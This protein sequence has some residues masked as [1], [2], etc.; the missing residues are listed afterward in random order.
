LKGQGSG[1]VGIHEFVF[2]IAL[3][4]TAIERILLGVVKIF[5]IEKTD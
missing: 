3:A 2:A 1:C 4:L 5:D